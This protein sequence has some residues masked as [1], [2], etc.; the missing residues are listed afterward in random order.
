MPADALG[1]IDRRVRTAVAD[2]LADVRAQ[3][4][5][6]ATQVT[7]LTERDAEREA[8]FD[9]LQAHADHLA[10]DLAA[11]RAGLADAAARAQSAENKGEALAGAIDVLRAAID[12][13]GD[14][15]ERARIAVAGLAEQLRW[16]SSDLRQALGALAERS[17]I[18]PIVD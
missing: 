11:L 16:E 6:L 2:D 3:V 8:R 1:W 5:A 9:V 10:A 17:L 13:R 12:E 7:A 15:A 4:A 14:V 18:R